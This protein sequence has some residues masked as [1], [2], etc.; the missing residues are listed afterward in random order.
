MRGNWT[1]NIIAALIVG[2]LTIFAWLQHGWMGEAREAE[3]E[4]MQRRAAADARAFADD[5]NREVQ[6]ISFNF[7]VDPTELEKGDVAEL[8]ERFAL[9]KSRSAHPEAVSEIT[10]LPLSPDL[11]P[12]RFDPGSKSLVSTEPNEKL[13]DLRGQIDPKR[14]PSL[15]EAH[16]MIVVPLYKSVRRVENVPAGPPPEVS[17]LAEMSAR[18]IQMQRPSGFLAIELNREVFVGSFLPV[19]A[20]KHFPNGDYTVSVVN[21]EGASIFGSGNAP[22]ARDASARLFDLTP[23]SMVFFG[24]GDL[25]Q[26]RVMVST[27]SG[28]VVDQV[29]ESRRHTTNGNSNAAVKGDFSFEFRN[30]EGGR[31]RSAIIRGSAN[32]SAP[33]TLNVTHVSGSIDRYIQSEQRKDSAVTL[34]IYFLIVGSILAV[35]VS[36]QRAKRFAQRQVDFVSGVSHE[37]RTP[38]AVIYSAGEN[39][40]DGVATN[41]VQIAQYGELIKG[42]GKK[43]SNMVEQI[44]EFAGARSGKR[45]YNP[46]PVDVSKLVSSAVEECRPVL[47][48]RRIEP[49]VLVADGLP[50]LDADR[51]AL[52]LAIQNLINNAAKYSGRGSVITV[53]A[54]NGDGNVGIS[55]A[56]KGIGIPKADLKHIFE[57]FFRSKNVVDAQI[58][59]NGLGLSLVQEI[60][61]AHGGAVVVESEEGKGS[62]FTLTIPVRRS[63]H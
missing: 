3:R 5:F 28:V 20:A 33:W 11:E 43:L 54:H 16:N 37:F 14:P 15:Y 27:N 22:E 24:A 21:T 62:E 12:Q 26:P 30:T 61:E 55:V 29:I 52:S 47:D 19:L 4:R 10:Y 41:G 36:A 42:E 32:E 46:E 48:E 9:W 51:A 58:H 23:E 45:I 44:L 31:Q 6:A 13:S 38:L 7:Q 63:F 59:G 34:A 56:D 2:L 8:S 60:A 1:T 49:A 39:L 25:R 50:M 57:P 17:A 40:A 18:R 35:V 53:S